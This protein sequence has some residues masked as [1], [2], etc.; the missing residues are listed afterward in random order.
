MDI[1]MD[2]YDEFARSYSPQSSVRTSLQTTAVE[3]AAE[4][5]LSLDLS[6]KSHVDLTLKNVGENI[7]GTESSPAS[8][9]LNR[10]KQPEFCRAKSFP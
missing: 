10:Q 6:D 5:K 8:M 7:Q 1:N 4:S 2:S 3:T 9:G